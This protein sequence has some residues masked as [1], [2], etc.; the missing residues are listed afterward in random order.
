MNQHL[1]A[2]LAIGALVLFGGLLFAVV[3]T[4]IPE[5][6]PRDLLLILAGALVTLV[7]DVFGFEFGSSVGS[8]NKEATIATAVTKETP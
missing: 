6:A 8:K 3:Y 7:K 5:G 1:R 2:V 4:P